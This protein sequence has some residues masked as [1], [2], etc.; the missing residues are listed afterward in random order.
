MVWC[1]CNPTLHLTFHLV[2]EQGRNQYVATIEERADARQHGKRHRAAP[3]WSLL[4]RK[5]N[6]LEFYLLQSWLAWQ[7]GDSSQQAS[8]VSGGLWFI[9]YLGLPA[10]PG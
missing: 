5:G 6:T 1:L 7:M 9:V 4:G 10:W 8:T 3:P 2:A